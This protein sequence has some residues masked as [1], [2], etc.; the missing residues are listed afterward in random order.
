MIEACG[1]EF[2]LHKYKKSI[3]VGCSFSLLLLDNQ[4]AIGLDGDLGS[5]L[6]VDLKRGEH[7]LAEFGVDI[8]LERLTW[9]EHWQV[10]GECQRLLEG[11]EAC[12]VPFPIRG[13]AGEDDIT[14]RIAVDEAGLFPSGWQLTEEI[15]CELWQF[16]EV[17]R[18]HG[19]TLYGGLHRD[20]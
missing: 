11:V 15:H 9:G 14:S 16:R 20:A 19:H 4:S 2:L 13:F 10:E 8:V 6:F 1:F 12:D 17:I 3:H 7:G 5:T 18:L